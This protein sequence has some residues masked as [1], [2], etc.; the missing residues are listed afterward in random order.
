M[1]ID[2]SQRGWAIASLIILAVSATAY[3][4]SAHESLRG[5]TGGSPLGLLFGS[6]GFGFMIFAALLGARKRVPVWRIG[7]SQAWMRGHLWLGLLSLPLILFHGGFHFGGL[8]TEVLMW[9][10]IIT[11]AS[12]IF[13]AILQHYLPTIMTRNVPLETIYDE[14]GHVHSLLR[15]EADRTME[16]ICGPLGFSKSSPEVSLRAGGFAAIRPVAPVSGCAGHETTLA[17][18]AICHALTQHISPPIPHYSHPLS[19]PLL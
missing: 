4:F 16:A 3:V 15:E 11:V 1:R 2:K 6:V 13:G 14:I 9:L 5:A 7:R 8:L 12:G 19:H 18:A 10:L 17:D